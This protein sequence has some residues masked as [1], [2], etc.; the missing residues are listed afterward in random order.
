M[1]HCSYQI[2]DTAKKVVKAGAYPKSWRKPGIKQWTE[3]Y[4]SIADLSPGAY[5]MV[6]YLGKEEMEKL[7][8]TKDRPEK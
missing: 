3:I 8:F 7:R 2:I 5:T 4:I 6:L 1:D